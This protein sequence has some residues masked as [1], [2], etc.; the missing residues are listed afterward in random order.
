MLKD[1]FHKASGSISLEGVRDKASGSISLEGV[2]ENQQMS[3]IHTMLKTTTR[4]LI[5]VMGYVTM[6]QGPHSMYTLLML[7]FIENKFSLV[8]H[9][10]TK[11]SKSKPEK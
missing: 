11:S 10:P 5:N 1:P 8:A 4:G 2:R 3:M 6:C 7:F 9:K